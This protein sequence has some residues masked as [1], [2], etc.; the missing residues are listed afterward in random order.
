MKKLMLLFLLLTSVEKISAQSFSRKYNAS[1][2]KIKWPS[3][4]D[5]EQSDFYVHNTIEI[6]ASPEVVWRLL[7]KASE[8]NNW[9]DGVQN[10][11]F[12]DSSQIELMENTKVFWSSMGQD[13]NNTV[14]EFMPY[15]RLAWTFIEEKIQGHHAWLIVPTDK[16][17]K[18]ITDESQTG[19]L[20]K[21]Q[22]IF[23]PRRLM[24]QHN[25]WLLRLKNEA[26]K[27]NPEFG[28]IGKSERDSLYKILTASHDKF[29]N[30]IQG[31]TADEL[32][33][34]PS[35][36]EWSIAECIE[37]I[38]LAEL[39]FPE[40]LKEE[41]IK[42]PDPDGRKRISIQDDEIR[43]KMTSTR[44]K[45][46]APEV[47]KPSNRFNSVEETLTIY[48]NQRKAT[49][50]YVSMTKDDLRNR[51][52]KHPLTG[53]IDLYQTL[54]LMSAHLERHTAQIDRIKAIIE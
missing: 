32:H 39:K 1:E 43:P 24:K 30:T 19:T 9:Y 35:P 25:D 34:K 2:N 29:L 44:W 8:W 36:S 33:F 53:T 27:N 28:V 50:E 23:I 3:N 45:A 54:L 38:T 10:I 37:H 6:E 11:Q 26:E 48:I 14:T 47:F 7:I 5:P 42:Q 40:I 41:M 17:C 21:L 12:K 16:G 15:Q 31:L 51:F 22:K 46:K 20:A 13:L 4:F 52:W 18:V 49:L